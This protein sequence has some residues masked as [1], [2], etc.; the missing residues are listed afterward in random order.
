MTIYA[1][2]QIHMSIP[3]AADVLGLGREQVRLVKSDARFRLDVRSLREMIEADMS[4]GLVPFCVVASAGTVNT[5]AV[6][7]LAALARVAATYNLWFHVDGAYGALGSLD[8]RKR[9]L[10]EGL[11]RA[12]S[13]SLDPHKWLYAPVDCG[14]LLFRDPAKARRAFLTD[15]ADYIKVHEEA[16]DE[17]F[18]FWDY[19]I[20]LSRRFRALK[21]WMMLCYY[22]TRRIRAAISDDNDLAAYLAERVNLAEEFELLAP[23]ELSICCFRYVP[24]A[25][26]AALREAE[27]TER[28]HL[29][30]ELD[31]LN[32]RIMHRVQRGGRAYLSNVTLNGSYGLRACVVNFRTTRDDIEQALDIVREAAREISE[33]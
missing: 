30:A 7:P 21:I 10:F 20:E 14:C 13:V 18:A 16:I 22:G 31:Q 1:S 32:A 19:G 25:V 23:V 9:P 15:D 8:E 33:E 3:K 24:P 29:N 12:D 17:S 28:A 2:D 26:H 5:G 27:P 6:D 4:R 11:E